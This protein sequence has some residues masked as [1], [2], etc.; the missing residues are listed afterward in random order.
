MNRSSRWQ[1]SGTD[2]ALVALILAALLGACASGANPELQA[3]EQ[4]VAAAR[5][6]LASDEQSGNVTVI[7]ED[8]HAF[9]LAQQKLLEDRGE[10]TQEEKRI[11]G[12]HGDHGGGHM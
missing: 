5:D 12:S 2:G 3:D 9:F 8:S 1:K 4:N 7:A 11:E 10:M 6:R